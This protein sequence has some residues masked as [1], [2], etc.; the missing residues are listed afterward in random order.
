MVRNDREICLDMGQKNIIWNRPSSDNSIT[1]Q[2]NSYVVLGTK[3]QWI[4]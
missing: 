4:L 3:E 2:I 1:I